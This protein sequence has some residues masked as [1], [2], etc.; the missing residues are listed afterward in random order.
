MADK[1][2]AVIG[3]S[4]QETAHLRL[5]MRHCADELEHKWRWGDE[6]GADLIVVDLGSFAGQM[7][8]TRALGAGMRCAVFSAEAPAGNDL[9]LRRPLQR[10]DIVTVLNRAGHARA[11]HPEI[12]AHDEDFYTRHL[13]EDGVAERKT[14]GAAPEPGLDALL[15]P[16]AAE[17]RADWGA[18]A[19]P[20]AP[21]APVAFEAEI[22]AM[23]APPATAA[24][25][26]RKYATR[27][28]LLADTTPHDLHAYLSGDLVRAPVRFQLLGAPP[29]VLD[30]KNR[31]AH[32]TGSLVE[33]EP[34][35]RARW[36]P[37]DWQSV[38]SAELAELREAQP[39]QAYARLLWLHALL[40]SG[41][42]LAR[43]LHPGGIYRLKQ[44]IGVEHGLGKYLRI[45]AAMSQPL[46]L[47]EIA[48]TSGVPMAEVFDFVN[49][50]DAIGL[51]E[52]TP[53]PRNDAPA[54]T[55]SLLQKLRRP[56]GRS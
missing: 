54:P 39:A 15:S 3:L 24:P 43:H 46:R 2:I 1:T 7:A 38:T 32:T 41:G 5:L 20:V 4:D 29:L 49:A 40:H 27:E 17:L 35:C 26:G 48:Q 25:P 55:A 14:D 56:F 34:Y 9:Q 12:E 21:V 50:G 51:I 44:W 16:L 23:D 52:W 13:G 11:R 47:H 42:Q 45:A 19:A 33:L 31:V 28:A 53:R 6:T 22:E 30:P 10:A 37:C 36:R 8:H 18:A